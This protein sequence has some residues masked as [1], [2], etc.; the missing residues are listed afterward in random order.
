MKARLISTAVILPL[1]LI[2]MWVGGLLFGAI[3]LI[4]S[5]IA[6]QECV[7]LLAK[8]NFSTHPYL[9]PMLSS[10]II[11]LGFYL[12][13]TPIQAIPT[14]IS[15]TLLS[16]LSVLWMLSAKS[17]NT[18]IL[19]TSLSTLAPSIYPSGLLM[20]ALLIMELEHG[21]YWLMILISG[22]AMTDTGA[23]LIGKRFGQHSFF[24]KIS[25]SKTIEGAV[26]GLVLG[27]LTLILVF[28]LFS[29][30][31]ISFIQM[32]ILAVTFPI[33][34]QGGDLLESALKRQANS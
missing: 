2:S 20:Q 9:S 27:A 1:V 7:A 28:N 26:G 17:D 6:S 10:L 34:A 23:Y 29:H 13:M 21:F 14:T 33:V 32:I 12:T 16:L 30:L 18:S 5:L 22:T 3:I 8:R 31:H 4:A 25:P 19:N 15:F 11:V 24:N